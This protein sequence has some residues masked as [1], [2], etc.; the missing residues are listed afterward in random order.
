MPRA[1]IGRIELY[2]FRKYATLLMRKQELIH[3][4]G[5]FDEVAQHCRDGGQSVSLAEYHDLGTRPTSIQHAK[6]DHKEA[7]FSLTRS[8]ATAVRDDNQR[9]EPPNAD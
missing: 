7:V 8:V 3:L 1:T 9:A 2:G 6:G 5:L 4:H